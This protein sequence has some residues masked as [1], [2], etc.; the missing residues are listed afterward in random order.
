MSG[1][2]SFRR[3]NPGQVFAWATYDFGNSAFATTILAVIFNKYYA[4][5][6]AGGA[7]GVSILGSQI[8]GTTVFSFF[9]SASMILVA[10]FGPILS[11]LS[12]LGQLKRRMLL[13]HTGL[14]VFATAMLATL[15]RGDWLVGGMWFALAQFGFAG[16]AIFYNAMLLDIAEPQDYAKVSSIG[17][18]WGYL[19][20]GLLLALNLVMLQYPQFLG[21]RPDSFTVQDCFLS[22]AIWW[23]IF[24]IP[25]ALS[26][27][28]KTT[29][30]RVNIRQA[31]VAL[32]DSLKSLNRL[33]SFARFFFA[34]L[35]Y[36]DGIETVIVMASIFGDQEL[37]LATG[38]LVLFFLMVQGVA[39]VG[40]ILFGVV[41]NKWNNKNAVLLGISIWSLVALWGWQLGWMGNAVREYW[42]LGILAGLVMGGTQAASRSL[43]AILIPPQKSAEFFSFFAISGKF[44]SAVGP[45]IFGLAVWI[46][47][48]LRVGMLSLLI[49]FVL[50]GW[51]LWGV[52]EERGRQEALAFRA[53][54]D[55]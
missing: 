43:Q 12:D 3:K 32:T 48:S 47:G 15:G 25:V 49:F 55:E 20:G 14:G 11:A 6:I 36:N 23:A 7:D 30:N 4:G 46:T 1:F 51:L 35:L 33:P 24:T 16:G 40:S 5:V 17:W 22:A 50:G 28:G 31:F 26:V 34:Y 41:A 37:H 8:P 52:S 54:R 27:K 42:L 18:A 38:E 39:F 2:F 10:L 13:L 9:V 19:G 21:A 53:V 29:T 44:A 45:A